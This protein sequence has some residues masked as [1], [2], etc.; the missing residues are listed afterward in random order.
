V[1]IEQVRPISA[2]LLKNLGFMAGSQCIDHPEQILPSKVIDLINT[3]EM[4]ES[5][6]K[7]VNEI[8]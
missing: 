5:L 2:H 4:L 6:S 3:D 7:E 8:L 1:I